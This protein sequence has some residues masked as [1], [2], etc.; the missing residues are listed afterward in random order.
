MFVAAVFCVCKLVQICE[1][2]YDGLIDLPFRHGKVEAMQEQIFL[3]GGLKMVIDL[4][5][6]GIPR[7]AVFG[8]DEHPTHT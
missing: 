6:V 3:V 5:A 7:F 4:I 2:I 1:L 8:W